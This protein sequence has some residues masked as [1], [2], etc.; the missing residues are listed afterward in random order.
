MTEVT[1]TAGVVQEA[2]DRVR[3]AYRSA[4][5][6]HKHDVVTPALLLDLPAARRNITKMADRLRVMPAALRPHIKVHKSPQLAR[7]QIEAGAIGVSTATVWEAIVMVRSGISSVAVVNTLAGREKLA[8][9]AELARDADVMVAIDEAGNAADIAAA[10]RAAGTTVGIL[11]EVDTGM[12]RAGVDTTGSALELARQVS[13]A[14]GLATAR[15]H[16][17]RRTL[18]PDSRIRTP[19]SA[20]ADGYE[21]PRGGCRL[22]PR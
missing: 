5:G 3:R 10:A 18:L 14:R 16:R 15:C 9:L 19:P 4:I 21:L 22:H 7:M 8:A 11:I 12:D 13:D 6:R 20:P 2:E 1:E 17:L